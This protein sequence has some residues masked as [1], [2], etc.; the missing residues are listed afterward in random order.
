[1]KIALIGTSGGV[2]SGVLKELWAS[3]TKFRHYPASA[4]S[5]LC[6][7]SYHAFAMPP[8]TFDLLLIDKARR[9]ASMS[10]AAE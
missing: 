1:M 4:K 8:S 7:R 9:R 10:S 5:R 6:Y 3:V 2:G